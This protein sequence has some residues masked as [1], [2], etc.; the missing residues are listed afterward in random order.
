MENFDVIILGAGPNGLTTGAYLAKA[1]LKVLALEKRHEV[2]GGLATEEVTLPGFLHNTHAIY[3]PMID[4]APAI[5]DLG[6]TAD[7]IRWLQPQPAMTMHFSDGYALSIYSDHERT[8][9]SIRQFSEKDARTY[10][11]IGPR[12]AELTDKFLAP[13]TYKEAE[14]VFDALMKMQSHEIGREVHHYTEQT[15]KDIVF[16]LFENERVRTLFLY[17]ACMWGLDWDL[18]GVSY[19]VP[20]LINRA[21]QYRLTVGGSHRLAHWIY[22]AMYQHGG[23]VWT[24]VRI[25][26]IVMEGGKAVGVE[27]EDGTLL[28]SKIVVSSLD[29]H[30]TF[31]KYI[32]EE[33][34]EADFAKRLKDY[35]WESHSHFTYHMALEQAPRF[36]LAGKYPELEKSFIHVM[37]FDTPQD[38][39]DHWQRTQKG[40]LEKSGFNCCF[41]SLFDPGLAPKGK[42]IGLVSQHVPYRINGGDP[43]AWYGERKS[44]AARCIDVL[45]KYVPN[46]RD[47]LMA[48]YISTPLDIENKFWDMKEGSIKQGAY[49]PLQMGYLRP[50]EHCSQYRTPVEGLYVCGASV[51]PG[52]LILLGAGY[53]AASRIVEDVGCTRWWPTPE[54]VARAEKMGLL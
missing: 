17:A 32:G 45:E 28:R 6:M 49:T 19:L 40:K 29:P 48:D 47:I 42:H 9:A 30:Q 51:F 25:K 1:G 10:L 54:K 27:L 26:R 43:E 53:N 3:M 52:G 14:P 35:R 31:F 18:E 2:G 5:E 23:R 7:K 13:A 39:I 20:L 34:L 46:I 44:H 36:E 38:L 24:S 8:S 33:H 22:K 41:Y 11:E 50:N 4:Y 12:F 15:P 21:S 37:G 16:S